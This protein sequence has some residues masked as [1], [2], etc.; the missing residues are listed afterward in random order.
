MSKSQQQLPDCLKSRNKKYI[1]N[2]QVHVY[3]IFIE[4]YMKRDPIALHKRDPIVLH[5]RDPIA[6]HKRDPIVL[7]KRDPIVLHKRD[8]IVL[9]KRE[10]TDKTDNFLI[11]VD[12]RYHN[13]LGLLF[14]EY[15]PCLYLD[16]IMGSHFHI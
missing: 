10:I 7:H 9:H 6:L 1:Y 14:A 3:V 11:K 16:D 12:S 8:P 5:K 2:L 4:L 15:F 13:Y